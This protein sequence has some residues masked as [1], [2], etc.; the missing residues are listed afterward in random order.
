[1]ESLVW[2]RNF[3]MSR[4]Q[5]VKVNGTLSSWQWASSVPQGS[6]LGPLYVNELPS[7]VSSKLLMFADDVKLYRTICSPED[8]LILQ[9]DINALLEWFLSFNFAKC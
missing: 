3:L 7:L 1:M 4:H 9:R 5:C 8:C 6:V 2:F